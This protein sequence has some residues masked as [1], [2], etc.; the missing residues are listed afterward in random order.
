LA[1][2]PVPFR[3]AA[4]AGSHFWGWYGLGRFWSHVSVK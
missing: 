2:E 3:T 1:L 4:F